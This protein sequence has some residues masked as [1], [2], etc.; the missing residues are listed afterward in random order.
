MAGTTSVYW[1]NVDE[2]QQRHDG[3]FK[4][5]SSYMYSA[6]IYSWTV[7]MSDYMALKQTQHLT[8]VTK[9]TPWAVSLRIQGCLCGIARLVLFGHALE[10]S[11]VFRTCTFRNMRQFKQIS[12]RVIRTKLVHDAWKNVLDVWSHCSVLRWNQDWSQH[13]FRFWMTT[14]Y[15]SVRR[16]WCLDCDM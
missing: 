7:M 1:S 12:G 13:T 15:I 9:H 8:N 4:M 10:T 3:V 2:K 5:T 11:Q 6:M 14:D 16:N